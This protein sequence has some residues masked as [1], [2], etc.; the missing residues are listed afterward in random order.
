M[1]LAP[2]EPVPPGFEDEVKRVPMCQVALDE[3]KASP[4]IGKLTTSGA[5]L[6]MY[7]VIGCLQDSSI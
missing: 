5:N 2:G 4:V 7:D 3:F 6:S 1:Q